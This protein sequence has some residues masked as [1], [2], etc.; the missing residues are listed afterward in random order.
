MQSVAMCVVDTTVW[1]SAIC[2]ICSSFFIASPP[3][4]S[5]ETSVHARSSMTASPLASW[6]IRTHAF[7][8]SQHRLSMRQRSPLRTVE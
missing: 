2:G 6:T 5:S 3:L 4:S 7:M 1:F 8:I